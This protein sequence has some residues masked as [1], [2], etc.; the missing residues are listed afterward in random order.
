[1][2]R[3]SLKQRYKGSWSIILDL[4]YQ[5]DAQTGKRKRKQRWYTVR[6]TKRDAETKL[7]ELLHQANHNTLTEPT[8]LTFGEWLDTWVEAAVKPPVRRLRTYESYKSIIDRH[9]KPGL[10][11]IL[12]QELDAVHLERYYREKGSALAQRTLEHHHAVVSRSLKSAQKKRLVERNVC[13]LVENTPKAPT[14]RLDVIDHC[15]DEAEAKTFLQATRAFGAQPAALYALGLDSGARK[16]ELCGLRWSSVDL[17]AG[18]IRIT[19]QLVKPGRA[20]VFGP[21]KNSN[22]R[23]I[24]LATQT[25][26]LLRKHRSHQAE[27]KLRNRAHYQDQGL[28]FAKEW[29]ELSS[30]VDTL[31]DPLQMN[32]IGQREFNKIIEAA[33]IRRIKFH[34]MRHTC[35]TL[36]LKAGV[37]VH[38]VSERL[39]HK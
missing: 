22:I 27:I 5:V 10:G 2:A 14:G 7:T 18:T 21:T 13:Q 4:G 1:M 8:N 15:W 25:V 34:G 32:N 29:G 11:Q 24:P 31:G 12:L 3:G 17:K 36:L 35:A 37:P 33:D 6:G 23:T 26:A 38:V 28:V 9:L 39:G 20:P 30:K 19:E 16:G